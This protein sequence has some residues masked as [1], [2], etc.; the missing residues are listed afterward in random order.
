MPLMIHGHS[1]RCAIIKMY[2]LYDTTT[3]YSRVWFYYLCDNVG[4]G[5]LMLT[6]R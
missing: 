5:M 6:G 2:C 4:M 3:L 1:R